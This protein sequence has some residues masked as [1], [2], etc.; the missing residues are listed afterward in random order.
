MSPLFL[1]K[2][3]RAWIA[4]LL[5]IVVRIH[6]A[7]AQKGP[8]L[9]GFQATVTVDKPSFLLGENVVLRYC[10]ANSSNDT[11][12][13]WVGSPADIFQVTATDQNG[14][15]LPA[16]PWRV[17]IAEGMLAPED[18]GPG[19]QWC[20]S[21]ALADNVR[22]DEGGT[23]NVSV[24]F[25]VDNSYSNFLTKGAANIPFG[26]GRAERECQESSNTFSSL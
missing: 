26:P 2:A 24:T 25:N 11:G 23:F 17:R 15:E 22:I 3:G 9:S 10:L 6:P 14:T 4:V 20:Q 16:A 21:V 8:D 7:E 19:K 1:H 5:L 12:H 13:I 18:I